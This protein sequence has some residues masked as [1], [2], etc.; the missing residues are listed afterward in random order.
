MRQDVVPQRYQPRVSGVWG[1]DQDRQVRQPQRDITK[2]F[3]V[4]APEFD[5]RMDPNVFSDWL[6]SI[7]EYFDWYEMIDS[8]RVRFAKMKLTNSAKMYWQNV[9][10][11]M[12]RLGEPPITQWAVM[13]AKLQD[14]YIPLSYKSQLF[15]T[16]INLKQM[17][18]SVAEYSA[19]FEEVR[20]RCSKFHAE[21]QFAVCTRFVNGLRF[22]IQ[23]MV[24]LHAPHTVEDAYQKALE[25]EKFS[26]PSSFAH[27]GQSKSESMSS[28]GNTTPNNIR[29]KE[30]ILRNSLLVAS[31]IASKTSNSSVVCHKCHHKGHIA[32]RCPQR[33]L[34][35]DVEQSILENEEDQIIDPIDYSGDEDD[36]HE[37]CDEDA[38]WCGSMC[39][40]H[41]CR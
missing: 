3:K 8:E 28:N 39:A 20:L 31:P 12:L 10:Q 35:L 26:R 1:R 30:S 17:T 32:S 4:N 33:A 14:K 37:N 34:A 16:M 40:I 41:N 7:E 2:K 6:V 9:L 38:C 11:D 29:S 13:K 25:V 36:L 23:R 15:S 19:K 22:D 21:D 18:L 5:G 24:R 27:T